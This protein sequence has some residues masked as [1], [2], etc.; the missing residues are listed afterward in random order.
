LISTIYVIP[1]DQVKG[2]FIMIM[3]TIVSCE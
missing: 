3:I 2:H 1:Q